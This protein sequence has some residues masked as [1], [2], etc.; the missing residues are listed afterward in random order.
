MPPAA[1]GEPAGALKAVGGSCVPLW[2]WGRC[3]ICSPSN[4]H[5]E[6]V[7]VIEV[8]PVEVNGKH[9]IA[10]V[11]DNSEMKP[12]GPF[13]TAAAAELAAARLRRFGRALTSSSSSE[14]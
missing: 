12:H 2:R 9:W 3:L 1:P 14:G 7:T 10:V 13:R 11:I 8:E 5:G 4:K 6:A